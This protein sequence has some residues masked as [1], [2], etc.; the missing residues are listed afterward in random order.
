MKVLEVDECTIM[1]KNYK[2]NHNIIT[3]G[4]TYEGASNEMS[5][6]MTLFMI[7]ELKRELYKRSYKGIKAMYKNYM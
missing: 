5:N 1:N 2:A 4:I 6:N 3:K 7:K